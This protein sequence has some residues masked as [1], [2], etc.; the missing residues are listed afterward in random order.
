VAQAFLKA[1][2]LPPSALRSPLVANVGTGHPQTLLGFAEHW[3][4]KRGATGK[5][6]PSALP[7]RDSEVMRYVPEVK[8]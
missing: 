3:W 4:K 2:E 1:L 8:S 7:Y 6:L 5:L